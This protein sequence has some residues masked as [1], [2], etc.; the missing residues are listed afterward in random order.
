MQFSPRLWHEVQP[1]DEGSDRVVLVIYQPRIKN[2]KRADRARLEALGFEPDQG[3]LQEEEYLLKL[4]KK[5]RFYED[6]GLEGSLSQINEAHQQLLEDL[7]ERAAALR[8]LLEEEQALAEDL[9]ETRLDI[10]DETY[11]ATSAINEMIQHAEKEIKE[12]DQVMV[13]TCLK[14]A[15]VRED[16][17]Y[18][19]LIDEMEGDLQVVYTVPQVQVRRAVGKW[20][21]AIKKELDNLFNTGTLRRITMKQAL[22]LQRQG[23]LRLVPSKGVY[24]LKP[25]D[26]PGE[27]LRR[28]YRL[29]LCGN[30]AA[31]EEGFGSLYAG[32]ASVE[33]FRGALAYAA[34][35]KWRVAASDITGAFL[36]SEWPSNLSQYA[37]QPPRFLID[38]NYAEEDECWLVAKPLYGLRESPSIWASY[39][40]ARLSGAKIPYKGSFVILQPSAVDKEIWL[41]YDEHGNE[42]AKGTLKALLVTYVDDLFYLGPPE[43][44]AALDEWIRI[45]WPCS[46]LP[47]ADDSEGARYL[48]TEIFQ[49]PSSAFELKQT[50]YIEDLLRAHEMTEACP[51]KLPCPREWIT[52]DYEDAVEDLTEQDLKMGQ[53][54]TGE[55]LWLTMRSRPDLQHVVSHLS[56]WVSK[57]PRRIVK[58]ARRVLSYLAGTSQMKLVIGDYKDNQSCSSNTSIHH[59]TARTH[60]TCTDSTDDTGLRVVSYSDASFAPTGSRS[61]GAAVVTI[62]DCPICWKSGRQG[63]V[64]LSTMESELLEATQTAILMDGIACLFDEFCN[65]RVDRILRVDNAAATAMLQGGPGS[66]RTRHLKVRSAYVLEQVEKKL[67]C[68]EFVEG[69]RQLADLGTKAHPKARLWELLE[70]WGCEN[71]PTEAHQAK[72][73]RILMLAL[74]TLALESVPVAEAAEKEPLKL[75]GVDELF[76]VVVVCCLGAIAIWEAVKW[77]GQCMWLKAVKGRKAQRLQRMR[78]LAKAAVETELGRSWGETQEAFQG[79]TTHQ[80]V[81]GALQEAMTRAIESSPIL[82]QEPEQRHRIPRTR[83]VGTQTPAYE[84]PGIPEPQAEYFRFEG[85]FYMSEH[86]KN[87]HVRQDCY[88]FR[89]ASHRIKAVG[90]CDWC[91]GAVPLYI[92]REGGQSSTR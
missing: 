91:A 42:K 88:G 8:I 80:R 35:R 73:M 4:V 43:L 29:V 2:L 55:L 68:V 54:M 83:S 13:A 25:P 45:E 67:L 71:L 39:R 59:S 87:V 36:L 82:H 70:L 40:T 10:E 23:K 30:H 85:P 26:T 79:R 66:W 64:T 69:K 18:E 32:G 92:R 5:R 34:M 3:P 78:D 1:H 60:N 20:H 6:Y 21:K 38:N 75:A 63:M 31:K 57:H 53:R 65:R 37:V 28:K 56:Q 52:E 7:Q 89:L 90:Y 50:G 19:A 9:R 49:R 81:E 12:L 17:D 22:E 86:G 76:L 44:I 11:K 14:A 41:A 51:T 74:I 16:P 84:R 46:A 61:V 24:T 33:T 62:N 48:G 47:W 58:I 77:L 27:R 15:T 72:A